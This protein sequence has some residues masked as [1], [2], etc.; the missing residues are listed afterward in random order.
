MSHRP[1]AVGF[2]LALLVWPLQLV[3]FSLNLKEAPDV[4]AS[5]SSLRIPRPLLFV[6]LNLWL[7]VF[8][9]QPHK[10]ERF[11]FPAY[12]LIALAGAVGVDEVQKMWHK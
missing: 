8:F 2:V 12:P 10:E 3:S 7:A 4:P 11:L 5:T 9:L 1:A 6:G